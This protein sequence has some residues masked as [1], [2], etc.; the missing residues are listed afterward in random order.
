M[1]FKILVASAF[2]SGAI[3][4]TLITSFLLIRWHQGQAQMVWTNALQQHLRFAA[5]VHHGDVQALRTNLDLR[6]P[7]LVLSVA[8]FGR[9]DQTVPLLRSTR[10]LLLSTGREVPPELQSVLTGL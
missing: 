4:S 1:R 3:L 10:E 5:D 9:N 2:L 7:G 6:L 8:S